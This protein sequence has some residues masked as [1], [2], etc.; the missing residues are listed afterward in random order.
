VKRGNSIEMD[1][2]DEKVSHRQFGEGVI[3]D[4]TPTAIR[5]RFSQEHGEKSFLYPSAFESFLTLDSPALRKRMNVRL[6]AIRDRMEAE[7]RQRE[8]EAERNR[9]ENR[10]ALLEQK[11]AAA[12][13]RTSARKAKV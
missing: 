5:V 13:K 12:K 7:R 1:I 6:R 3:I 9:E 10:R 2:I 4:Q 8:E 11:R